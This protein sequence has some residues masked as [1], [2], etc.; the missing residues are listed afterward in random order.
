MSSKP[1]RLVGRPLVVAGA[2]C[3]VPYA[4]L[5]VFFLLSHQ[6]SDEIVRPKGVLLASLALLG[7]LVP[8]GA[9]A[10]VM[11]RLVRDAS[12][13]RPWV[14]VELY[15]ALILVFASLY[16]LVQVGSEEP[17]F[18]NAPVLWDATAAIPFDEHMTRM[19][20]IFGTMLYL[21]VITVTTVGFGD[22]VPMSIAARSLVAVQALLGVSFITI[23]V[24]H[25][26]SVWARRR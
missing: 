1:L 21:S 23:S 12:T 19:H 18:A 17:A 9:M 8:L 10:I 16:A 26:F 15:A 3:L 22:I 4:G 20:S 11:L 2:T 13:F 5:L 6:A 25:Y 24:G 7:G 14:F